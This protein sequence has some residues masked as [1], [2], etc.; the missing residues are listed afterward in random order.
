MSEHR[1]PKLHGRRKG[2]PLSA[3]RRAI[4]EAWLPRLEIDTSHPAPEDLSELFRADTNTFRLEIGCGAGEHLV[5]QASSAP[6]VGFIGAEPFQEGLAKT[7]AAIEE[8]QLSNV[9]LYSDDAAALLDWLPRGSISRIDLLYPDPWLKRRHWKRRF[10]STE[11]L[12]RIAAALKKDGELRVATDITDYANWTLISILARADFEWV[13][14][15]ADDWRRPWAGWPGTRYEAKALA[16]GRRP[17]Y[18]IF[19]RR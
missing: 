3:R 7:V 16:A 11:N 19:R 13:A 6:D 15:K 17:F 10:V 4:V 18:L 1:R 5:D 12:D 8:R 14:T 2:R 9:R